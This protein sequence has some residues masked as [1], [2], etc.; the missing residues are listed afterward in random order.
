MV[1]ER[2]EYMRESGCI[3]DDRRYGV[4]LSLSGAVG[5]TGPLAMET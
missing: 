4:L 1:W 3:D 2:A 5:P